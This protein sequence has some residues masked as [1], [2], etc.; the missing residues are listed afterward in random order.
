MNELKVKF[1]TNGLGPY[2]YIIEYRSLGGTAFAF[3]DPGDDGGRDM[4]LERAREIAMAWH[5]RLSRDAEYRMP[6]VIQ[7]DPAS[8]SFRELDASEAA[9]VVAARRAAGLR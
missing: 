4:T 6:A 9:E 1:G 7:I 2:R 5:K 3:A 8:V